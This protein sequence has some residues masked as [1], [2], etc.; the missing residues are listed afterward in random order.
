LA[1][2]AL[3]QAILSAP[4]DVLWNGG[5]GTYIKA[6]TETHAQVNDKANDEERI[7][8][9]RVRATVVGEGGNLGLTPAARAELA[10]RGVRLNTDAVDNAGGVT[11]SD[12]EV[13]LKLALAPLVASGK[14]T[15]S[16]RNALLAKVAPQVEELVL[17]V[18]RRQNLALTLEEESSTAYHTD[19][20]GWQETL[21]KR[22]ILHPA[23]DDVPGAATLA[24]R[25]SG[26]Y[27]R[28]ELAGLLSATKRTLKAQLKA[29]EAADI[30]ALPVVQAAYQ[31]YFPAPIWALMAK[32]SVQHPLEAQ[33]KAAIVAGL[34]ADNLGLGFGATM[35]VD[36]GVVP[37]DIIRAACVA[38]QV[39]HLPEVWRDLAKAPLS[40]QLA[41]G[42]RTR[43]VAA[44][45]VAW[46]L[47]HGSPLKAEALVA[48]LAGPV[49]QL[50]AQL[51]KLLTPAG[52][53]DLKTRTHGWQAH[54]VPAAVAAKLAALSPLCVAPEAVRVA[55]R[56]GAPLPGV[57]ALHLAVGEVL[58]LPEIVRRSR[59]LPAPDRWTRM[60][61]QACVQEFGIRQRGLTTQLVRAHK[62]TPPVQVLKTWQQR[63]QN[64]LVRYHG[65]LENMLAEKTLSVAMLNVLVARLRELEG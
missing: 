46:L 3:I 45:L 57:F 10:G 16:A 43:V 34:L 6:S 22:G 26:R 23:V 52:A 19:L 36:F 42:A 47:R 50:A 63:Q 17:N 35:A 28:P 8:A 1:P 9:G 44:G 7:S 60:A 2:E 64:A 55:A 5:I 54:G 41:A 20:L 53:A 37:L 27:L 11:C 31:A 4:V 39:L 49:A 32:H 56:T 62:N 18:S 65:V 21:L 30:L 48:E 12:L 51:P 29:P 58:R 15:P 25:P 40:A 61:V 14:L 33:L 13:N 24:A 59:T 38:M